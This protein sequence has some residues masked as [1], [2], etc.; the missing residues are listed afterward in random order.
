MAVFTPATKRAAEPDVARRAPV[1][2]THPGG[3]TRTFV[4]NMPRHSPLLRLAS[5]LLAV[6]VLTASVGFR[7]QRRTCRMSGRS[8]V[9]VSMTGLGA[10]V[11]GCGEQ[12]GPGPAG[13]VAKGRCCDHRS[14]LHQLEASTHGSVSDQ[15]LPPWPLLGVG[16][17]LAFWLGAELP[18][19]GDAWAAGPRWLAADASPPLAGRKLLVFLCTLVI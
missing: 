18:D 10:R 11:A 8:Q 3:G 5:L 16:Q 15:T 13:T 12:P 6:L 14:H 17:T 4:V 9:A 19:S 7:V 2:C 1:S